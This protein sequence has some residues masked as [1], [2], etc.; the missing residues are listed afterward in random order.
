MKLVGGFVD[1]RLKL[2]EASE[3]NDKTT[4][5]CRSSSYERQ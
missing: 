3:A 1:V 4:V 5:A 2:F